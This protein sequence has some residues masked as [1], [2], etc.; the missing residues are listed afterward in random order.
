MADGA[1]MSQM[2]TGR[3]CRAPRANPYAAVT[4]LTDGIVAAKGRFPYMVVE[5]QQ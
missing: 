4:V 2:D 5:G 3:K 1:G